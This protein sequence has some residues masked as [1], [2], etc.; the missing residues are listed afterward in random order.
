MIDFPYAG[1]LYGLF[2]H[3]EKGLVTYGMRGNLLVTTDLATARPIDEELWDPYERVSLEDP[4]Q[5]SKTGWRKVSS[6]VSESLFS[7][8]KQQGGDTLLVGMNAA[9]LRLST[10]ATKLKSVPVQES[11]TLTAIVRTGETAMAVGRRGIVDLG[12]LE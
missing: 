3:G 9:V 7:H 1:S 5:L 8:L 6:P 10:D 12:T 11:E 4:E 2:A